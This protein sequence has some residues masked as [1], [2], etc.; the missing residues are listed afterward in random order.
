MKKCLV[1]M[2]ALALALLPGASAQAQTAHLID[3]SCSIPGGGYF[4]AEGP[5]TY[6][7]VHSYG[8]AINGCYL[9]TGTTLGG[10]INWGSYYLP[11]SSAENGNYVVEVFVPC[12]LSNRASNA[13]YYRYRY[14][15]GG[16]I[17]SNHGLNQGA[18]CNGTAGI[19]AALYYNADQGGYMKSV[20]KSPVA[21]QNLSIDR[22]SFLVG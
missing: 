4:Y 3:D 17:T 1:F 16:G 2:G 6:W 18:I 13:R 9:S 15:T 5:A 8:P 12:Q 10:P 7:M 21:N 14:G 19:H 20:D 11:I 22:L